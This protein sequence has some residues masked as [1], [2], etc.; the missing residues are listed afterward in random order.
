MHWDAPES[1]YDPEPQGRQLAEPD[2]SAKY[3][4]LQFRQ[5][6]IPVP[7]AKVPRGQSL[8]YFAPGSPENV[9]KG[10]AT[11]ELFDP[12]PTSDEFVPAGQR[13][14]ADK[15]SVAPTASE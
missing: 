13:R 6:V 10:H 11:H 14:Q 3:P 9:P 12:A 1:E 15:G 2:K 4:A 5:F 8:Q 7:F